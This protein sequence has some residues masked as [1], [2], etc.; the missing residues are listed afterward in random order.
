MFLKHLSGMF[1]FTWGD[2]RPQ[3]SLSGVLQSS[4]CPPGKHLLEALVLVKATKEEASKAALV[5]ILH[6]QRS[7]FWN[8]HSRNLKHK[9][10][11]FY[12]CTE[13]NKNK[14]PKE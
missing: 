8:I 9:E 5:W 4:S 2:R 14:Q 3:P 1:P 12:C 10:Y 7:L 11:L 6:H 13:F